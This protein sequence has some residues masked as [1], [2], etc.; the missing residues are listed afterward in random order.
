MSKAARYG[1]TACAPWSC[2]SART[3]PRPRTPLPDRH[4]TRVDSRARALA[5]AAAIGVVEL[6]GRRA[7][8]SRAMGWLGAYTLIG[9]VGALAPAPRPFSSRDRALTL[10][11][12]MA[13]VGYP[14]LRELAGDHPRRPPREPLALELVALAVV[15]VAEELS[16]ARHVEPWLGD[17]GTAAL[18]AVKH[19]A[20]D[21]NARR[22]PA[23]AMFWWGLAGIRAH[24]K[25][26]AAAT[27][28]LLNCGGV[29]LGHLTARDQF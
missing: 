5:I 11:P 26:A 27:H 23:L 3:F 22:V 29:T 16:W 8:R 6:T 18:F 20:I 17:V 1:A 15:A 25:V 9:I 2:V 21:G 4:A 14:G 28:V 12:L 19:A 13:A 7:T 10:A 24:S